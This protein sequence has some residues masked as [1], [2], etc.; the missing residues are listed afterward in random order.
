MRGNER[1]FP[2]SDDRRRTRIRPPCVSP[3]NV[4]RG[5]SLVQNFWPSCT[6]PCLSCIVSKNPTSF[7]VCPLPSHGSP[8]LPRGSESDSC[9]DATD[10]FQCTVGRLMS[11]S[12]C[13]NDETEITACVR[14]EHGLASDTAGQ[15]SPLECTRVIDFRLRQPTSRLLR[16]GTRTLLGVFGLSDPLLYGNR[17][18]TTGIRLRFIP[19]P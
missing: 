11:S 1:R 12:V 10:G 16:S 14:C 8:I 4:P 3:W 6:V 15:A 2:R 7:A 17:S 5:V 13:H 18:K 19:A 9:I